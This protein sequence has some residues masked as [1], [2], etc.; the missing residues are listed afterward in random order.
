MTLLKN[1]LPLAAI[2]LL[3]LGARPAFADFLFSTSGTTSGGSVSGTADFSV[4]GTTLTLTLTNTT[5]SPAAIAQVLDG[6]LFNLTGA[7]SL[8]LNSVS[9]TNGFENCTTG[10]CTSDSLFHTYNGSG[11]VTG[12]LS[13]PYGWTVS[14]SFTLAAGAGSLHPGGIVN[15]TVT[16]ADGIPNGEHNDYLVGPVT[17]IFTANGIVTGVSGVTFEWGTTPE[18]TGGSVPDGGTTAVLLSFA[19]VAIGLVS[20][21]FNKERS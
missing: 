18:T 4:S 19:L 15:T 12:T 16:S 10:T 14:P 7:T 13:S 2:T 8:T 6:F 20:R 11:T 9:A 3:G 1:L 21:R 5:A 17:F